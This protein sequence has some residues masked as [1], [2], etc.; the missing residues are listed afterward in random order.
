MVHPGHGDVT[1]D[2]L[3]LLVISGHPKRHILA[4]VQPGIELA[5]LLAVKYNLSDPQ[6]HKNLRKERALKI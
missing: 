2:H 5:I 4:V 6:S 3:R 1:P